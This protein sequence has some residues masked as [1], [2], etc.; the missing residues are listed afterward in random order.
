M[1]AK[2]EIIHIATSNLL[3][4]LANKKK[5]GRKEVVEW[6]NSHNWWRVT[7]KEE[8]QAKLKEWEKDNG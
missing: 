5:E 7:T 8:W 3:V 1:E 6:V 2:D 4:L